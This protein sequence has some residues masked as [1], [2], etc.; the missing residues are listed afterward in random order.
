MPAIN[1]AKTDTF[2]S[3]RVKINQIASAIFNVTAGGSDL[4]TG[5]LKLGDGTKP[6]PSL[7]F[8]NEPSLGFY[9]PT[10]KTISF[11]SS[12]KNI[13]DIEESQLTLF[14]DEVVRKKSIPTSGGINITRGSGYE[15]GTFTAVPLL[16]GSGT[17]G[18]GTFFVDH[19]RGT[20]GSGAGYQAGTFT[21][22]PLQGGSG[23]GATVDFTVTGLEV[24]VSDG[25]S[26][27]TDGFYS[28]VAST[29]VSG[30]GNG[31][32][33]T[34]I[35]EVT[36]GEVTNCSVASNGNNQYEANDVLTVA[37]ALLGG[38]GGS[39]LEVT[40]DSN[41]GLLTFDSISKE[42]GYTAG[43]VL[44]L[45]VS[46]TINN[47]NI[48]GTHI[49]TG[50][51]LTSGSTTVTLGASTNEVIPGMVLAVDQGGS[52]GGFAG[53]V[54]V[55]VVSITNGTTI[56][57]DTA[58]N[59]T[60]AANITFASP[61]PTILTIPGGTSTLVAGY[62]ITG[63]NTNVADGLE[64]INVIDA[65]TVEID[66]ASTAPFYQANLQFV[67]KWGVGSTAFTYTIDVVGAVE[68]LTITNGGTGYAIGDVLTVA[69]TDLVK[70]IEYTVKSE[71]V[72]HLTFTGT[73]ASS[74]FTV[75]DLWE[76]SE[77]SGGTFE[78]GFVKSTGGNVD[79]VLLLGASFADGDDIRKEGTT[80]N[81]TINVARSPEGKFYVSPLGGTLTYAPDLTFYVGERYRF[82]LDPSMTSHNI[83]FSTFPDGKWLESAV[84]ATS[85]TAGTDTI[86]VTSTT[87]IQVGMAVEETG[88]DP[89]QLG[90]KSLV[91]EIVDATT[92]RVSP[93]PVATGI[94]S[95]KFYG[96][97]YT[98]GVT[99]VG[100]ASPYVEVQVTDTTP[101]TL[102]YYC[103]NHPNMAGEDGDEATITVDPTN[104]RVFGSGFAGELIDVDVQDVIELD[105]ET[106]LVKSNSIQS[107]SASFTSA[108]VSS[109]LSA[110]NIS[111]SVISLDTINA[112]SS[113]DIVATASINLSGDV[114]LGSYATVAKTTGN[115]TTTGEIK[116]TTLFNS[117]DAL[118]IE[119][120]NIE[121]INNYDLEMTPF[122]GRIAKVNTNTAF[123]LPV[124][125]SGE[126]PTGLAVD[127]SI[128]FNSTT[129]QYEGYSSN[130]ASWS[131]LGG[132]RDLDGNTYILAELTVG[133][134]DNTLHFVNDNTVT[135]R[136]TPFWHEYVNVKQVRSVNTTAPTYTEFIANAPVSEGDY[137]KWRNNIYVV[138]NGGQGTTATS[139]AEPT[140][141]TGT[142]PN[143]SAQLEWF[144][145]AVAPLTF[146]EIE[147]VRIS[148]LGFTPLVISGDLRLF[149]NKLSTDISDLVLQPNSG[150]RVDVNCNTTLTVPVGSDGERGSAIQGGI[151]F[152][153]TAG[154]FEGYDGANWGSLGGVK[155]VDQ[156][157]YI[158]P[159][160][161]PGANENIL[162]FYND[163]NNSL[164][165][166]TT[167][168][169]FYSVD[170][171]RSMTSD[172][173]EITASLITFDGAYTTLDN[174]STT[175][176]FLHSS[177]QY[178]DLGLSSG[179][180]TEPVLRLDNQGDVYFNTTF[181]TG[182][183][184]GVKVFDGDLTEFELA[185]TTTRTIDLTL[186]KG[187]TNTGGENIY[188]PA[189]EV[190]SK[191]VVTAH[192]PTTGEKE[193]IE[194]GII[195]NGTDVFHTEYGNVRTGQQ[196]II[197]TFE[198]TGDNKVRINLELGAGIGTTQAVNI[199]LTS[200][201]TKK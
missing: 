159:E 92:V 180:Y 10:S 120:A 43:N 44:T 39:G 165:L 186:V 102:Y 125:T 93:A 176:T 46:Q 15:F 108:S 66:A 82:N 80:T 105:V 198:V 94:I 63:I 37:D 31:S 184:T 103:D 179:L 142:Q 69:A 71:A 79:Y 81:Y 27:Y 88:N 137:V 167:A 68:T 5:I 52:V 13:L 14:K 98:T 77:G 48:G 117:N 162:Y 192:N 114:A 97:E 116:S 104:P 118:K 191:T 136:F 50:C 35:V 133:A 169:D 123:V 36:G 61:S 9:R 73:V 166:T 174:T 128:R 196:L 115:I 132:V 7:A 18:Q 38:G 29:N 90:E 146:E 153:T 164:Q 149:G 56:E 30:S 170:T 126:R 32:G 96:T 183:F 34:L 145:S 124:G 17:S 135:Q 91:T 111:G 12:S 188:T 152:S 195:D 106:G 62:V 53:G 24:T 178:F 148:P 130:S 65:N 190:G 84:I 19:F 76:S 154:Q 45:P 151:R 16:G 181:G 157:T 33:A 67:P 2:E 109:T 168:L 138:P 100:G 141:T 89:G 6:L 64:I 177:K 42:T 8:N 72:Q 83:K 78:V 3:Q 119:N 200:Q 155:D 85:V 70:P 144:A 57:V 107:T 172:E 86:N 74:V 101:S 28:G 95:I 189:V 193:Y 129:N 197:P 185:D 75:G 11:V 122:A 113:L 175:T 110:S 127:G 21:G 150:K 139:G 55:T 41:A 1:V 49:S 47:I 20:P 4:S 134:N 163:G 87:G 194:F 54:T 171:I 40:V 121:S 22:V 143:G 23:T 25:G 147:E 173:L 182:A 158:I 187:T 140:H 51:T 99:V 26:G 60:G 156:N 201:I 199:T 161:S 160:T 131:S 112:S 59:A 58:A